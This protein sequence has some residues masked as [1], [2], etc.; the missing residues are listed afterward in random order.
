MR[1]DVIPME[2]HDICLGIVHKGLQDREI[3]KLHKL[4]LK[5]EY[6]RIMLRFQKQENPC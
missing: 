5:R 6:L 3:F 2:R 1:L 4:K